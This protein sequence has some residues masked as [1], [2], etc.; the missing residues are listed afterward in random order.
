[1][2]CLRKLHWHNKSMKFSVGHRW[3]EDS[4]C[5]FRQMCLFFKKEI[6]YKLTKITAFLNNWDNSCHSPFCFVS[7]SKSFT[8]FKDTLSFFYLYFLRCTRKILVTVSVQISHGFDHFICRQIN[9]I[10]RQYCGYRLFC[11]MCSLCYFISNME[12]K[13]T[14]LEQRLSVR[15]QIRLW[16]E[17]RSPTSSYQLSIKLEI[18]VWQ[19]CKINSYFNLDVKKHAIFK[20]NLMFI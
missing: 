19:V 10:L 13:S 6:V 4:C 5:P 15:Y 16:M 18:N 9:N 12:M 3:E 1:M 17:K 7:V 14:F 20:T 2:H 11:Y 8:V